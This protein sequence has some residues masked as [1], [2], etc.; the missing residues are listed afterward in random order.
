MEYVNWQ[1]LSM[2]MSADYQVAIQEGASIVRIGTAV[3]GARS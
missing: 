2:G 3:L 1:E